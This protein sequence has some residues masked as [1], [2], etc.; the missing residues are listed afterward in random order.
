MNRL[1]KEK[2][3]AIVSALVEGVSIRNIERMTGVHQDTIMRL[4]NR[5]G[6]QCSRLLDQHMVG[7]HS[8]VL[9]VDELWTFFKKKGSSPK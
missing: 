6:E 8:R 9:Q 7:F 3:L 5:V 1:K 4:L 2:E